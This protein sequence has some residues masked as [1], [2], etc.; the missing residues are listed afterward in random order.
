MTDKN[1][2]IDYK[3][4]LIDY[5]LKTYFSEE[6]VFV[7]FC[8]LKSVLTT[9]IE[10]SSIANRYCQNLDD[11]LKKILIKQCIIFLFQLECII[12]YGEIQFD[13]EAID[14]TQPTIYSPFLVSHD[15]IDVIDTIGKMS[16]NLSMGLWNDFED[17]NYSVVAMIG[18]I[19]NINENNFIQFLLEFELY[20]VSLIARQE[21]NYVNNVLSTAFFVKSNSRIETLLRKIK[22]PKF[23]E[24]NPAPLEPHKVTTIEQ[25][26]EFTEQEMEEFGERISEG[27]KE[28]GEIYEQFLKDIDE[29]KEPQNIFADIEPKDKDDKDIEQNEDKEIVIKESHIN[30]NGEL[31]QSNIKTTFLDEE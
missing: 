16:C 27:V 3:N 24:I 21:P 23:E 25:P 19:K 13:I 29:G 6:K 9:L 17:R 20:L 18:R 26:I 30:E 28:R 8:N 4:Q 22:P 5:I 2:L 1:E 14:L 10:I 7:D 31:E 11:K 12:R 15:E